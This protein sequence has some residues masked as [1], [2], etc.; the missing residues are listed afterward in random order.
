MTQQQPQS[1]T[2]MPNV[3]NPSIG[4]YV[5]ATKWQDGNSKD[6]WHVGYFSKEDQGRYFVNDSNG[7]C[8]RPSG[9]RKCQK[10]HPAIGA[11]LIEN[12]DAISSIKL[13]LWEY[14]QSHVHNTAIENWDYDHGTKEN[15]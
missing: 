5:L 1:N 6:H 9:F 4:D 11:Y 7:K 10:I 3:I 2:P 15:S 14:I 13:D 12:S 8:V